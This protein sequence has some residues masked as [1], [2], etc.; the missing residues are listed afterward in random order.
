MAFRFS[1]FFL[2][3]TKLRQK[4]RSRKIFYCE[5]FACFRNNLLKI[6]YEITKIGRST[7]QKRLF[8]KRNGGKIIHGCFQL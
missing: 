3:F 7:H 1:P 8:T 6:L 2:S 4:N 5:Y